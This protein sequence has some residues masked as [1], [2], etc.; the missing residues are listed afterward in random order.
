VNFFSW[1]ECRSSLNALWKLI[2]GYSWSPAPPTEFHELFLSALNTR[3]VETISTYYHV[4]AV[5]ITPS[6]TIQG[7]DLIKNY[8]TTLFSQTI[9][10]AVFAITGV[11]G[12]GTTRHITWRCTSSRGSVSDGDD[13]FG[14]AD[15]KI[16]YHYSNYSTPR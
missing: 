4:N 10:G 9:P 14:L 16:L 15:N 6:R 12:T 13:T 3:N 5:Q 1:D 7:I 2:G 11:S 8:Y